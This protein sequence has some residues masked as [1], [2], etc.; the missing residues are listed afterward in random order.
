M[1]GKK[2]F[3]EIE[4]LDKAMNL[5]WQKGYNAT[6]AQDLVDELGISRSSLY[7]T[8]GDKHSLFVKALLKYRKQWI[9]PAIKGANTITDAEAYI[10]DLFEFIKQETFDKNSTKGCFWV[11]AAIEMVPADSEVTSIAISIMK[12]TENA[13]YKAIK[14]GQ[15]QGV[16]TSI[17]TARSLAKFILNAISGLRVNVKLDSDEKT[18]D[19]IMKICLS[20][21]K[22]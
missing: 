5:F 4:V 2:V 18:F 9:D 16:F 19:D 22:A 12:D 7:D 10:V 14:K 3:D 20:V 11:N 17:H 8:F 6:S 21:L 13:F 15:E 1:A